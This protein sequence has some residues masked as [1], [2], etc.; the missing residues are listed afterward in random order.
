MGWREENGRLGGRNEATDSDLGHV[1]RQLSTLLDRKAEGR[2]LWKAAIRKRTKR[3]A[4][5]AL[6]WHMPT[7]VYLILS[8]SVGGF[9]VWLRV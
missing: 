8:E 4:L 9:P 3:T 1:L 5:A 6:R 2:S 7:R